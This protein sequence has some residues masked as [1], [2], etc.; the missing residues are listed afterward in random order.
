MFSVE[1]AVLFTIILN[2]ST[3]EYER[4]LVNRPST[5]IYSCLG[6]KSGLVPAPKG[7]LSLESKSSPSW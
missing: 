4:V 3:F 7:E 2:N 5:E 6:L 1:L